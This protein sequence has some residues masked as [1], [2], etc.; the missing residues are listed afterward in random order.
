MKVLRTLIVLI[1][2]LSTLSGL[3]QNAKKLYKSGKDYS[4]IG[5]FEKAVELFTQAIDLDS[6]FTKAILA[7]AS[8]YEELIQYKKAAED[9]ETLSLLQPGKGDYSMKAGMFYFEAKEYQKAIPLL[10]SASETDAKNSKIYNL[11]AKCYFAIKNYPEALDEINTALQL[12]PSADNYY[13]R[14]LI[15]SE[16][17]NFSA[18]KGDFMQSLQL[19]S[20]NSDAYT[21]LAFAQL[22]LNEEENAI[23]SLNNA[24]NVD[25]RNK[26]AYLLR[27]YIHR[28]QSNLNEAIK[29]LTTALTYF[30]NDKKVLLQRGIAYSENKQYNEAIEDL[31]KVLRTEKDEKL[32]LKYRAQS[33]QALNK[34]NEAIKDYEELLAVVNKDDNQKDFAVDIKNQLFELQREGN[35][36]QIVIIQK[37][38][39]SKLIEVPEGPDEA[40][41]TIKIIDQSDL[42]IIKIDGF[43]V[44]FNQENIKSGEEILAEIAEKNSLKIEVEDVYGNTTTE[45]F[46][47]KRV[48][49]GFPR[50]VITVPLNSKGNEI[51]LS[52]LS[53]EVELQGRI[54]SKYKIESFKIDDIPVDFVKDANNPPFRVAINIKDKTSILFDVIDTEGNHLSKQF[55]IDKADAELLSKNPM[56]RTW[57]VFVENSDYVHF[58]NLEGPK[59]EVNLMVKALDNYQIDKVIHKKN[60]T[61]AQMD[62]FFRQELKKQIIEN[63]VNSIMVWYAGHGKYLNQKGYW[64]P[65]DSKVD[66][67][68]TYYNLNSLKT[69]L[70]PYTKVIT[71]SLIVTDACESGPSF[72]MSMRS[73]PTDRDCNNAKST[74]L[75]SS[76]VFTSTRED[77]TGGDSQFTESFANSLIYNSKSCIPIEQIVNKVSGELLKTS[78]KRPKFGKISGF[79]DE[80][81]SFIFIKK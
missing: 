13:Q 11:K 71:H 67:L 7:R 2:S 41:I 65:V 10:N 19:N 64:I 77:I 74:K 62:W 81:G 39:D 76:Q 52:E 61:K 28:K 26:S 33:Y 46:R 47:L 4:K 75:K 68:S 16:S 3:A 6:D 60:M 29:D 58:T 48:D 9:Y 17:N 23:K 80:N 31:T 49:T 79:G 37:N 38:K 73:L 18:A 5:N 36:P 43:E 27:S 59:K 21:H 70:K 24:I 53:E 1:I 57:V 8:A 42:A 55:S 45:T 34:K 44:K 32:A 22:S 69:A 50:V 51:V 14:G 15:H 78:N 56:G 66:D 63:R 35:K 30:S 20:S 72:Y 12:E 25:N 40:P 54:V